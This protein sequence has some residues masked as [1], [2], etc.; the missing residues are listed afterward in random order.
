ML[1]ICAQIDIQSHLIS[2]S[3]LQ[4]LVCT[5]LTILHGK[6]A[7]YS[8]VLKSIRNTAEEIKI[9]FF[10]SFGEKKGTCCNSNNFDGMITRSDG[11]DVDRGPPVALPCS[12]GTKH[13]KIA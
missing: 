8:R 13:F 11:S 10:K 2:N 3:I 5:P 1:L 7:F 6:L 12:R 9:I 4:Q